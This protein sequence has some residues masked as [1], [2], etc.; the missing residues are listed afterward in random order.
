M[1]GE[2][3]KKITRF[4]NTLCGSYSNKKQAQKQPKVYAHINIYFRLL[5]WELFQ[6][7]SLYSEQ[8][9]NYSPWSPYRQAVHKLSTDENNLLLENYEIYPSERFAG[10]GFNKQ[11]LLSIKKENLL[12]RKNCQ[13]KFKEISKGTY[14]GSLK[15]AGK[16][17]VE[18]DGRKT[19][20]VSKVKFN[21]SKFKTIDQGFDIETN[22]RLWGLEDGFFEFEKIR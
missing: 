11:I 3:D 4:L 10:A 22:K 14:V 8:S 13:M 1:N 15:K 17:I 5:P 6:S 20:L 19:Y 7:I 12:I 16:C 2:H 9:Y 21:K 18:R